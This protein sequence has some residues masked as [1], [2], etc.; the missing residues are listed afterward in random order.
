MLFHVVQGRAYLQTAQSL[1]P[2]MFEPYYNFA[3]STYQ[4]NLL[5]NGDTLSTSVSSSS[6]VIC[7]AV[8]VQ[9]RARWRSTRITRTRNRFMTN[10]RRCSQNC[11]SNNSISTDETSLTN[12]RPSRSCIAS[13]LHPSHTRLCHANSLICIASVNVPLIIYYDPTDRDSYSQSEGHVID[14]FS[15]IPAVALD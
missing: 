13:R 8:S 6:M 1:A 9:S 15:S 11:E 3:K 4:V 14:R 12:T 10:C 7:R 2:H 5:G